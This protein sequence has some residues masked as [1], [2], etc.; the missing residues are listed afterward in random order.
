MRTSPAVIAIEFGSLQFAYSGSI[1]PIR[2]S[3]WR[4]HRVCQYPLKTGSGVAEAIC[5]A[6]GR[7]MARWIV[8]QI[9]Q[10]AALMSGQ[11]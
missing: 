8:T 9:T 3:L 6:G 11:P 4:L 2:A 10:L 1:Q 7:N 5:I